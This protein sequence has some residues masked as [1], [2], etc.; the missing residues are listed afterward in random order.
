MKKSYFFIFKDLFIHE[1]ERERGR[2]AE[3]EGEAGSPQS[4]EPDV[5]LNPRTL[6]S[7]PEP[8]ADI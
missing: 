7:Q 5:G 3:A 8:K 6:G 4:Q 2:D 1:R